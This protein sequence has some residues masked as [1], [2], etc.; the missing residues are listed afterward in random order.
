MHLPGK[1]TGNPSK[2]HHDADAWTAA[3]SSLESIERHLSSSIRSHLSGWSGSSRDSFDLEAKELSD[4]IAELAGSFRKLEGKLD[5]FAGRLHVAQD[6]Y[7]VALGAAGVTLVA[8]TVAAVFTFGAGEAAGAAGAAAELSAAV[9]V[10]DEAVTVLVSSVGALAVGEAAFPIVTLETAT[11]A[12]L[13]VVEFIEVEGPFIGDAATEA[14]GIIGAEG[15]VAASDLVGSES[16][17]YES[18]KNADEEASF[19]RFK[20]TEEADGLEFSEPNGPG[21]DWKDDLGETYDQ[22]GSKAASAHW[23]Y[24]RQNFLDQIVRHIGKADHTVLDLT[25]FTPSQIAEVEAF[26]RRL[27]PADLAKIIRIGF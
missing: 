18:L 1:P 19:L 11:V 25:G 5:H 17:L 3:A 24:Q 27:S 7:N 16:E 20:A 8:G 6:A 4:A 21:A 23:D 13:A 10:A 15:A 2:I 12:S 14:E 26:L 22:M 9:A